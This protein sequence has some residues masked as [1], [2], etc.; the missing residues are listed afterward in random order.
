MPLPFHTVPYPPWTIL[1]SKK[2]SV[3]RG[4]G[5]LVVDDERG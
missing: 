3:F 5:D 4:L 1:E 2:L